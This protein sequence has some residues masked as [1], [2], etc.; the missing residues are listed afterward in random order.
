MKMDI[1][2]FLLRNFQYRFKKFCVYYDVI[3]EECFACES[4]AKL[5]KNVVSVVSPS[6]LIKRNNKQRNNE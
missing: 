5:T 6:N 1:K 3:D 2:W 4:R